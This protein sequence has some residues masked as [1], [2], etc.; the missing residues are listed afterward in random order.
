M[1][2][3]L[4]RIIQSKQVYLLL[5]IFLIFVF[6]LSRTF[7]GVFIFSY[8]TGEIVFLIS[9]F[10]LFLSIIFN[11]SNFIQT[12]IWS[13]Q[14]RYTLLLL[15]SHFLFSA[16]ISNS[17]F[18]NPYIYRSSSYLWSI[19][20]LYLSLV[21]FEKRKPTLRYIFALLALL[22][23]IYIYNIYGISN[24]LQDL[25]LTISDK[26]EYHK[27]SDLLI[28]FVVT[29]FIANRKIIDK[30]IAFEIFIIFSSLY[31]PILLFKSRSAFIA[32]FIF[33]VLEMIHLK[34]S[35]RNNPKR[36]LILL[37]VSTLILL[38]SIFTVTKSGYIQIEDISAKAEQ[39]IDYRLTIDDEAEKSFI[40]IEDRR[41]Y[42]IDGNLN[43]RLQIWQDVLFDLSN[44][45]KLFIGYGFNSIIPAMEDPIRK[46]ADGTNENVHN[47]LVNILA[48]GGLVGLLLYLSFFFFLLKEI[49]K[50]RN[51]YQILNLIVPIIFTS[52][53][54]AS[55]EN[56]HFPLLFYIS[57]GLYVQNNSKN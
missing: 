16:I 30:R 42:S 33:F 29:F 12:K 49:I 36:S 6:L 14:I 44:S 15:V 43:W 3:L 20:F 50:T 23:W 1:A 54:D 22:L 7:M 26:F 53:F 41:L 25:L 18:T 39:I 56:A 9:M 32:F 31:L 21:I 17:S 2:K 46:G 48:R 19:G 55:M 40:Y 38:Q 5:G 11:P 37:I 8:R 47:F 27:G 45:N 28:M 24:Q 10:F 35:I 57:L 52:L 51:N 34:P 4:K 13:N